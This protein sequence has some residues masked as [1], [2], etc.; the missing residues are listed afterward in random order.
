MPVRMNLIAVIDGFSSAT[1]RIPEAGICVG[2]TQ[3]DR[4]KTQIQI[5][6]IL[7]HY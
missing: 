1:H 4:G 3:I 6:P 2:R 5:F 7:S